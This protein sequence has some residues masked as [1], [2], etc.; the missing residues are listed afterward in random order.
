M[1]MNRGF[2]GSLVHGE[3]GNVK[4]ALSQSPAS[5]VGPSAAQ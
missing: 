3:N 4:G 1:E 2:I 5:D